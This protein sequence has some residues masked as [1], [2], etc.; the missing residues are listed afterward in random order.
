MG[1]LLATTP[2]W[3]QSGADVAELRTRASQ[4][5][6][7]AQTR[8]G[9][10][11]ATG[12]LGLKTDFVQAVE[13]LRQAAEK[14]HASAQAQLALL[15]EQGHGVPADERQAFKYYLMAA[16]KGFAPAQATVAGMYAEGRGVAQDLFASNLWYRR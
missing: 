11:Y 13:L 5:D 8:L 4:G 7:D 14:G 9:S 12:Q 10:A 15:Y 2:A 3:P 1:V 16:E 6:A